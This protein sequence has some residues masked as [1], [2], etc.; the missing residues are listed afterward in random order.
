MDIAYPYAIDP[1][2]FTALA[3]SDAHVE[4]MIEQL[5]FTIP[6]ERVNRPD[7]G[8]GLQ[9]YVF[10]ASPELGATLQATVHEALQRW[11]GQIIA[12]EAVKVTLGEA[13][14]A[15]DVLYRRQGS[16]DRRQAKLR[17]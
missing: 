11:M 8:C 9:R 13:T 2:G 15:V 17:Y 7:F 14:I 5:L 1:R 16:G 12:V 4:Q 3:G 6:G 10:A